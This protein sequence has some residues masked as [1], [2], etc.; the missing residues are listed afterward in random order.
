MAT[1]NPPSTY[2]LSFITSQPDAAESALEDFGATT[3]ATEAAM[4]DTETT[5]TRFEVYFDTR[6]NMS[7]LTLP[8]ATKP[9]LETLPQKDWV[10]ESQEGLPPVIVPPFYLHGRHDAPR[11][12]GWR[13]IEIQAATAFGSAH[14]GTTQGCLVL[15]SDYLKRHKPRHSADI[16]CGTG[17][18]AIAIA[19]STLRDTLASDI[20]P[21]AVR[22]ARN[23]IRA[24][25]V[26]PFITGFTSIG[27][28]HRY[29]H[30]RLFDL[31]V[32]NILAGPL[33]QLAGDFNRHLT[34]AGRVIIA[35]ILN[36]QA[37]RVIARYRAEGLIVER[38]IIIGA[39]TS[40]CF[41]R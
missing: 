25:K 16:G 11:G 6:P 2:K 32:A 21:D 40:L 28:A 24:N 31:I 29:Y 34:P 26:S 18:L 4:P 17:V 5:G 36:E 14:H 13:D 10:T 30:G 23:N 7:A 19:K 38:K 3:W 22:V 35:G 15:L 1:E 20:D 12:G 39:W 37:R 41:R 8:K 33:R 9:L 27:M